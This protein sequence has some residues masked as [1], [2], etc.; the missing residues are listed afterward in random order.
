MRLEPGLRALQRSFQRAVM[1]A[2]DPGSPDR[3][4]AGRLEVYAEAFFWRLHDVLAEQHEALRH[5]V[6]AAA[7]EALVR[8]YVQAH[9]PR[10]HDI[11]RAGDRLPGFLLADDRPWL[12][13]LARLERLH[14]ELFVA[15]DARPLRMD[16]LRALAPEQ[17]PGM[18]LR[19]VPALALLECAHDV[20][21]LWRE[22]GAAVAPP[23]RATTR[24]LVWRKQLAVL[25][26]RVDAEE[27]AA[28]VLVARGC[29]LAEL[30]ELLAADAGVEAASARLGV[31]LVR[32]IDDEILA[33][34]V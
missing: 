33:A 15:A 28:L 29:P 18:E 24:L 19:A 32:W 23:A 8:A 20:A 22:P 5:I 17:L 30:G 3:L 26:R 1:T 6:G 7:F 10:G 11:G 13:E 4:V 27:W 9:P 31:L 2:A 16:D 14:L 12:A 25:H 21:T 34:G